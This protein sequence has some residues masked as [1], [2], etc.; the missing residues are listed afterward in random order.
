MMFVVSWLVWPPTLVS[1]FTLGLR[2]FSKRNVIE[3]ASLLATLVNTAFIWICLACYEAGKFCVQI[4]G[5][6]ILKGDVL[7]LRHTAIIILLSSAIY[8]EPLNLFFYTWRFLATLEKEEQSKGW[9]TFYRWFARITMLLI[10]A[11]F[12]AVFAVFV[13]D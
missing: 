10:P 7:G 2:S 9:K 6:Q 3:S 11:T 5:N 13:I 8:L 12:Y 1:L 4:N